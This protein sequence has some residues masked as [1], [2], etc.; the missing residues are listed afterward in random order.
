MN[1]R[2]LKKTVDNIVSRLRDDENPRVG[3]P[4]N[5][6]SIGG[7]SVTEVKDVSPGFD[8]DHGT[9]F[10][11]PEK[12][13]YCDDKNHKQAKLFDKIYGWFWSLKRDNN[14]PKQ[15]VTKNIYRILEKHHE[16]WETE[17]LNRMQKRIEDKDKEPLEDQDL[18]K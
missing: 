18:P 12:P 7:S 15:S 11:W 16:E 5:H 9:V 3:I 10:I 13:L 14:T 8:W 4:D 17:K 6:P 1:I 2:E